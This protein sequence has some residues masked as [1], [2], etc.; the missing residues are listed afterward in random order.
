MRSSSGGPALDV[1][2]DAPSRAEQHQP[3]DEHAPSEQLAVQAE[4][5]EQQE[6]AAS[7]LDLSSAGKLEEAEQGR[8][9]DA[10]DAEAQAELDARYGAIM[11]AVGDH[12]SQT[13]S[14]NRRN[15][16]GG[17]NSL[18]D[19]H[20]VRPLSG[21]LTEAGREKFARARQ[22]I[23]TQARNSRGTGSWW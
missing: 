1:D 14:A 13:A 9:Q 19:A 4:G 6:R 3:A 20:Q 5:Q 16:V 7:E 10:D 11:R 15:V 2:A 18:A 8:G 22:R 21:F 17:S 23:E 12:F